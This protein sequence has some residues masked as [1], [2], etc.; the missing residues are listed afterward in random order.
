MRQPALVDLVKAV[1]ATDE[2]DRNTLGLFAV[3]GLYFHLD[4]GLFAMRLQSRNRFDFRKLIIHRPKPVAGVSID[5]PVVEFRTYLV[6]I[7]KAIFCGIR[8]EFYLCRLRFLGDTADAY[9]QDKREARRE[10]VPRHCHTFCPPTC[11][12]H[13]AAYST[14]RLIH[15]SP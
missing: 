9:K 8:T 6:L 12:R 1:R 7:L 15:I 10:L 14:S 11:L 3:F 5:F 2:L 13:Q 4:I